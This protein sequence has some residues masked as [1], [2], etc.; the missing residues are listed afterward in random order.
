[1][2]DST[3]KTDKFAQ[4]V[5]TTLRKE[6]AELETKNRGLLSQI[7]KLENSRMKNEQ[8]TIIA[9]DVREALF[10]AVRVL[11]EQVSNET[12]KSR[13]AR[14]RARQLL[15]RKNITPPGTLGYSRASRKKRKKRKRKS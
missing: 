15:E 12:S 13:R 14:E 6:N 11:A 1:M 5:M 10:D 8:R 7:A 9:E 2:E 3:S 4:Q